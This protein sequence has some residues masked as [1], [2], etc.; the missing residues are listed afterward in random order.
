VVLG[1][2]F[3]LFAVLPFV[4]LVQIAFIIVAGILI[5]TFVVRA[6]LVPAASYDIGRAI[7]WPSKLTRQRYDMPSGPPAE[8]P[9]NA[10]NRAR[11]LLAGR[12]RHDSTL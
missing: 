10:P 4:P 9:A 7:W 2:T 1:V 3:S 12:H 5:D 8:E 11:T 6:L